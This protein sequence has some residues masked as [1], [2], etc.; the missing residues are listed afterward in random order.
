MTIDAATRYRRSATEAE[1]EKA[2]RDAVEALGGRCWHVRDS[3][4]MDVEDM[5]DLLIVLP[6]IVALIE[7]KSQRRQVTPGQEQVLDLLSGCRRIVSGIVRPH[8]KP[9]EMSQDDVL[10][11]IQGISPGRHEMSDHPLRIAA[12]LALPLEATTQTFAILAK[13]GAGKTYT[14][15]VLVEELLKA[16][17]QV[18][19][20]DPL[21][22]WWGLRASADGESP[23]L[24][25]VVLGGQH[26]D[27][28]LDATNGT[29]V[30]D[31]V[32]DE[33]I[34]VVLSLRHLSKTAQR[35]F[36]AEFAERLYHRKGEDRNRLPLHVVID[37]ADAFVPQR[38]AGDTARV[39]GAVDDLV[40]RG[41]SS[42]IGVTL[43]TQRAS[44][45]HKDVLTQLEV[46]I[47][48]R[49][50]S[51]QD[52]KAIESWIEAHD[53]EDHGQ[54]VMATLASLP[55]G[56]AWVWS[57]G[58]LELLRKVAIRTRETF[59]SSATPAMGATAVEPHILAPV[60]LDRIRD[61]LAAT[62]ERVKANDPKALRSTIADLTKR[63]AAAEKSREAPPTPAEPVIVVE[64]RDRPELA[65]GL[66]VI[67]TTLET[68]VADLGN[69]IVVGSAAPRPTPG[70]SPRGTA[71]VP[72][73]ERDATGGLKR[74]QRRMLEVLARMDRSISRQ[75]LA[76]Q[77]GFT[78]SGG[79]FGNYFGKLKSQGLVRETGGGVTI[80]DH[81]TEELGGDVPARPQT[82]EEVLALWRG[83]LKAGERRMLDA[84]VEIYPEA[85]D[86]EQLGSFTGFTVSGGHSG[87][88]WDGYGETGSSRSMVPTFGLAARCSSIRTSD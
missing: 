77:S 33:R 30:A 2:I 66:Q 45:I 88:T 64:Y 14:A 53:P 63:L 46:L 25:I 75:E 40:R 9:G 83:T 7:L 65:D 17:S 23:G 80:T 56:T 34:P 44:V 32:V 15:S 68:I 54:E 41:R 61:Q 18:A 10:A 38:V 4:G 26:G 71:T 21:D 84:L 69:L 39:M 58:W 29:L 19:V 5:P 11:I 57:P 6:P 20:L 42:G 62:V 8:P 36:V 67:R 78:A 81:G 79:T 47:A 52:R 76:T 85:M 49:T 60:D 74:G 27:L 16:G 1:I 50:V 43:I 59:D 22:S 13:R 37:E 31:L 70:P 55:I 73:P 12:D 72:R 82:T 24:P 87:T 48:L 28:P 3:R 35:R 51:P 86:R